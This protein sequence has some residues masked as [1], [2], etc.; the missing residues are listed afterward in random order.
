[1]KNLFLVGLTI[2]LLA[3]CATVPTV[4]T[5][6]TPTVVAKPDESTLYIYRTAGLGTALKKDI[7]INGEC[8]GETAP[9]VHF[10]SHIPGNQ[11]VVISTESE[12]SQNHVGFFCQEWAELLCKTIH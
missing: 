6:S 9:G 12:F 8:L 11:N 3:G 4:S 1:M 2:T 5:S 7:W 10:I